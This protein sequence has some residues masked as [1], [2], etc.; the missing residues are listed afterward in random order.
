MTRILALDWG[1]IRIGVAVSD[2][3]QK[4]AFPAKDYIESKGGINKIKQLAGEY[5]IERILIGLPKSLSGKETQ[6]TKDVQKF[7]SKLKK[8]LPIPIEFI[9][10]RLTSLQAGK[11]LMDAGLNQNQVRSVKDNLSAQIML[12]QYLDTKNINFNN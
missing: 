7:A 3:E 11:I 1:S 8:R 6:S 9:D 4:I 12:Q 10:E 2:E 5:G